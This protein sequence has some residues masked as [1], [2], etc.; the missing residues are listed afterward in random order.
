MSHSRPI[1][2]ALPPD[3]IQAAKSK[4]T[5]LALCL[6][7][8]LWGLSGYSQLAVRALLP[9]LLVCMTVPSVFAYPARLWFRLSDIMGAVVSRSVLTLI[10]ALV[11]IPIGRFRRMLGHDALRRREWKS[12]TG[13][14]FREGQGL[15]R[16]EH[17][18]NPF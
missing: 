18:R 2:S 3:P 5:G 4:D 9:V 16:P 12:G 10:F 1:Q 7:L 15:L 13:S 14:A 6:V 17:L 11:V 8:V